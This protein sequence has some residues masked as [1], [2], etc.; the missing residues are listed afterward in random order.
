MAEELLLVGSVPLETA[1]EVFRAVGAPLARYL[2]YMPDG[3]IGDRQYWI[4][5]I[6]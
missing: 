5:G 2:A 3:E 4:D 6:A 1:E